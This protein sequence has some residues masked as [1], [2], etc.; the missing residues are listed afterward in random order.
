[1]SPDYKQ[2]FIDNSPIWSMEYSKTYT[3][4]QGHIWM[5]VNSLLLAGDQYLIIFLNLKTELGEISQ[6]SNI[7][8]LT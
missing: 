7:S 5:K 8:V 3:P 1:M 2:K 4:I 6:L